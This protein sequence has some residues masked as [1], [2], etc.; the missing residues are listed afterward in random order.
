M[1]L[2]DLLVRLERIRRHHINIVHRAME[3]IHPD[4]ILEV[5]LDH[6]AWSQ[7][8]PTLASA[9]GGISPSHLASASS[10]IAWS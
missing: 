4:P 3:C 8:N 5:L 1:L 9:S 10:M 6:F 7:L 2:P